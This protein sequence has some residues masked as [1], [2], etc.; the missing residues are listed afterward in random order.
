MANTAFTE[1]AERVRKLVSPERF[2][3]ILRVAELAERIA[4]ANGLEPGRAYLA[5]ILHDA[6][7]DFT[8]ERLAEL[9]PPQNEVER[10]HPKALHGR[11]GRRLA[12]E[13]G[14]EDEEVLEA[15]EG[16]VYGVHPS[17]AIAM[18]VY[19]ADVSEPGRGVNAE[20]RDLALEGQ[21]LEAYRRAVRSKVEYLQSK[22]IPVHP[23]T[24][25][26]YRELAS[27]PRPGFRL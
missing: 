2:A 24:L 19:V 20:I 26:A 17:H 21:L 1:W 12:E 14:I 7:R 9:A 3:H 4:E 18:A 6:A 16:H 10:K 8:P 22:G 27:E 11:A 23:R 15:I 13:W 25:E 5:G